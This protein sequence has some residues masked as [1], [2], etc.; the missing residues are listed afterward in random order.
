MGSTWYTLCSD[1]W[2][3]FKEQ[4]CTYTSLDYV[5][6]AGDLIYFGHDPGPT[7]QSFTHIAIVE[8]VEDGIVHTIEG[9]YSQTVS[10]RAVACQVG[11]PT[12]GVYI[13]GYAK[14]NY[15]A[16]Q[17][18]DVEQYVFDYLTGVLGLN[19][20]AA[21][22]VLA[23]IERES[24]FDL[25]AIGDV[26]LGGSYGLCQWHAG[27]YANL[28]TFCNER[29]LDYRTLEGQLAYLTEE[30]NTSKK[31][32]LSKLQEIPNTSQGAYDAAYIWC[33]YFE[34]PADRHNEGIKRGNSAASTYWPQYGS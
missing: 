16:V 19:T 22:G 5:P 4:G 25:G 17:A 11:T 2:N 9:N 26:E 27:R 13:E 18:G 21:C 8:Y 29:N 10:K 14:P 24:N 12:D 15:P 3:Y 30:L 23:N 1:S 33:V 31:S 7:Y 28:V 32:V 34:V 6:E 20:A